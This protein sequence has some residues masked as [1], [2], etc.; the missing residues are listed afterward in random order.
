MPK[1]TVTSAPASEPVTASD[2]RDFH[3]NITDSTKETG[4]DELVT[5]VRKYIERKYDKA[6]ITQT[7]TE[8]FDKWP[9][10]YRQLEL[11]VS[12]VASVTSIKYYDEDNSLQT[13][14]S[15]NYHV[16]KGRLHCL[17]ELA[18]GASFPDL[19]DKPDA[20]EVAYVAGDEVAEEH[21]KHFIRQ[22]VG[23]LYYDK[24]AFDMIMKNTELLF[25]EIA[26]SV[27]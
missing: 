17:I 3:L 7:I 23:R 25:P 21:V 11:A 27:S 22:A 14:D 13:W 6:I 8:T 4:L 2:F 5:T 18:D 26:L 24:E 19:Y 12:P 1:Y 9:L 10:Y 15:S 20:I 16:S